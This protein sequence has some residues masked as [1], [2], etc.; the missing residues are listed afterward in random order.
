[1]ILNYALPYR[2]SG[3][4]CAKVNKINRYYQR[5]KDSP[6]SVDSNDAQ[7]MH[8]PKVIGVTLYCKGASVRVLFNVQN[9]RFGDHFA[10]SVET[11]ERI[12]CLQC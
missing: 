5:L 11:N 3:A 8:R 7:I 1:M 4:P 10:N 9:Q 2:F 6:G 12:R